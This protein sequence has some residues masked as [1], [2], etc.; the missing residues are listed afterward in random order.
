MVIP[1]VPFVSNTPDDTHCLQAAYMIIAKHFDSNFNIPMNKWSQLTG[2]EKNLGT[3]ANAGLVWFKNNGYDVKHYENFNFEEF[4]KRPS[5]YMI[6]LNGKAAGEW[7]YNHTNVPNE[8]IRIEQLL[9][10]DIIESREPTL[11]DIL[12]A[13]SNGYLARVT[14]NSNSL[15]KR[16]GYSGHAIVIF[17][18]D[19]KNLYIHDP[20]L[21]A[22]PNRQVS[23]ED[24]NNA[25]NEQSK[26]LDIIRKSR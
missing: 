11:D 4:I 14:I 9:S 18:Y 7:G 8:I 26:E 2:Y 17:G 12:Y 13:V 3:W 1:N 22:I 21:P 24:F 16:P 5:E 19:D 20:G 25:W 6:E 23:I 15:N 10:T